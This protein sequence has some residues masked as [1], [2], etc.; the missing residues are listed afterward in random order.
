[1]G[2]DNLQ[3]HQLAAFAGRGSSP[4]AWH[5]PLLLECF[6]HKDRVYKA[7]IKLLVEA[8]KRQKVRK[9]IK[10]NQLGTLWAGARE[11]MTL[12]EH[13]TAYNRLSHA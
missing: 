9:H 1:M 2:E 3:A 10:L 8:A 7:K 13:L 6:K 5:L 12:V 11:S 4:F